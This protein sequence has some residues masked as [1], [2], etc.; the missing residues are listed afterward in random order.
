[1]T[2]ATRTVAAHFWS[3]DSK[4]VIFQKDTGG[5]E[6]YHIYAVDPAATGDP[7]PPARDLT[8]IE[9]I[10]ARIIDIPKKTPPKSS[11]ESTTVIRRCMTSTGSTW[12]PAKNLVRKN[13]E[14]IIEWQTDLDGR[15][16]LGT[17]QT[18]DGGTEVL[19]VEGNLLLPIYSVNADE[20][21]RSIRLPPMATASIWCPTKG[22]P[23]R[24][25]LMLFD[26]DIR[27]TESPREDPKGEADF[28]EAVFSDVTN[29]LIATVYTGDRRRIYFP[30]VAI[31]ERLREDE[32]ATAGREYLSRLPD[33]R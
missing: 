27:Q 32:E 18:S 24:T 14:N 29:E 7:V 9:K 3:K 26:S 11:S 13:G 22:D 31:Q 21:V 19:K 10:Q 5:D 23:D 1:L 20:Y 8:P 28:G 25:Q 15:L 30:A 12:P 2:A 33:G 4:Y 6:N 17:R 16:R